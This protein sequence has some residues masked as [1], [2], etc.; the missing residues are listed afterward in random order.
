MS[1]V[2]HVGLNYGD[3]GSLKI[4]NIIHLD[5]KYHNMVLENHQVC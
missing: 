4:S 5:M 1:G 2:N 3:I